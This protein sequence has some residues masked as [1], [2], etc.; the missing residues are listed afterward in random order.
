M[1][2][3]FP[4]LV[5]TLLL[6]T[7]T[8]LAQISVTGNYYARQCYFEAA[9]DGASYDSCDKSLE[10][11]MLV[12]R[13]RAATYVN[14]AVVYTNAGNL[15]AALRD[16][17]RAESL[18]PDL[19]EIYASRGNVYFYQNSFEEA[20]AE[21]DRGIATG[22]KKLHAAHYDRGL[23]LEQLGRL[24]EAKEAYRESITL[25]PEFDLAKAR[26]SRL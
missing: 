3:F 13:D 7:G 11:E 20:L 23:A 8:A 26:L 9:S 25:A 18:R 21:Y 12:G 10:V 1:R 22:M 5:A 14:R 19:G 15:R 16:L 17:E 2:S 4:P 24:Q 6:C